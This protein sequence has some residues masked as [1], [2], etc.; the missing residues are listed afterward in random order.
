VPYAIN[1]RPLA[2]GEVQLAL[3]TATGGTY[4]IALQTKA[5]GDVWLT[6]RATGIDT[7]L[8]DGAYSFNAGAGTDSGRFVLHFG[9][10]TG[11]SE[12]VNSQSS[13]CKFFDL[14]GRRVSQP[15]KGLYLRDGRKV[16][17]K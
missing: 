2:D 12:I 13:N 4:T 7:N 6:D 14:Q 3:Q 10:M 11:V 9:A 16:I 1:E 17:V 5:E 15:A 8:A